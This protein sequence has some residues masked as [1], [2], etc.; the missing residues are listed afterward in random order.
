MSAFCLAQLAATLIGV[1]ANW[2]FTHIRGA[3]WRWALTVWVWNLIWFIPMDIP[4]LLA[5][6]LMNGEMWRSHREHALFSF[7]HGYQANRSRVPATGIA[8]TRARASIGSYES[9][10]RES[11]TR[12]INSID[13]ATRPKIE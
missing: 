7:R 9:A 5:K 10:H 6:S 12:V 1:Y 11:I 8:A 2:G 13:M 4:K 3:G